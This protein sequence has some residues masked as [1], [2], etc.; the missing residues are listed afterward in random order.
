VANQD[1]NK[2]K[3]FENWL[4]FATQGSPNTGRADLYAWAPS[5]AVLRNEIIYKALA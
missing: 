2:L 5:T 3:K 1:S 4:V